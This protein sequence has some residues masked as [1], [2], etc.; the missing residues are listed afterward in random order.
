M[1]PWRCFLWQP[2]QRSGGSYL[3]VFTDKL[4]PERFFAAAQKDTAAAQ[5]DAHSVHSAE[6]SVTRSGSSQGAKIR[7][8]KDRRLIALEQELLTSKVEMHALLEEREA[9][10]E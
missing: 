6:D 7:G 3:V 2:V 10:N 4:P 1:S 8:E 5:K 9:A